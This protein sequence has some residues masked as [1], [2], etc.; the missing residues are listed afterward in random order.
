MLKI[1]K[2]WQQNFLQVTLYK[3]SV[4]TSGQ[5]LCKGYCLLP[6][7]LKSYCS[8]QIAL[9]VWLSKD[10]LNEIS[11]CLRK[12]FH[13]GARRS[14]LAEK[15]SI[16]WSKTLPSLFHLDSQTA[17]EIRNLKSSEKHYFHPTIR[18]KNCISMQYFSMLSYENGIC[19][20]FTYP[21]CLIWDQMGFFLLQKH[22]CR[23]DILWGRFSCCLTVWVIR[24]LLSSLCTTCC[25]TKQETEVKH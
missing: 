17:G 13:W 10:I 4:M 7:W 22:I 8:G 18:M 9:E 6:A 20:R 24:A 21:F 11:K 16:S 25:Y 14:D 12:Q 3:N 1:I 15:A 5:Q 2:Y 19:L 23:A